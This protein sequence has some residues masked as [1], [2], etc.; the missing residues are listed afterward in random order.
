MLDDGTSAI[1]AYAVF[2]SSESTSPSRILLYNSGFFDGSGSRGSTE[3]VLS[4]IGPALTATAKR[5]TAPNANAL[6]GVSIGGNGSFDGTCKMTGV[7][8]VETIDLNDGRETVDVMESEAVI[9][10]L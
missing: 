5:L 10:F 8:S 2:D 6:T 3:V 9:I 4:D 1:A 7:Q